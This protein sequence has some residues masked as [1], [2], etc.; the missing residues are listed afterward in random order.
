MIA[1]Y[2]DALRG[3]HRNTRLM[4]T[5]S[6]LLGFT[7]DGGIYSV[8]LNLYILRLNFGPEFVGLVNSVANLVFAFGCLAAGWLGSRWGGRPTMIL[9]LSLTVVGTATLPLANFLPM[10]WRAGWLIVTFLIGYSGLAFY[11]V[12][13]G[14]FLLRVTPQAASGNIFSLQSAIN[15]TASFVGGLTG[16]FLPG[17][18]AI[19]MGVTLTQPAPYSTTL[20]LVSLFIGVALVVLL[21]TSNPE[22]AP[23]LVVPAKDGGAPSRE[24]AYGLILFMGLVRFLQVAGIGAAMVF[25]NVYMDESLGVTTAGI[26]VAAAAARLLA[27][28]MALLAPS[29]GRRFGYG[30]TAVFA[31]LAACVSLL[32]LALVPTPLA[33]S[34]G[35]IG[36]LS[37]TSMRWPAFYVYMME[38]TPERLRAVM[39]GVNEMAAG[40]SFAFIALVGGI[41]IVN[42]GYTATFLFSAFLTLAGALIFAGFVRLRGH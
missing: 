7:I 26:G 20:F 6:A 9:G 21:Q 1:A 35:F 16:G 24:S 4:L 25:F 13:S 23:A 27:V 33:A 37:F 12:N 5:I 18:F 29:L 22:P 3:A 40:L 30:S 2:R 42:Y 34:M 32:P 15:A 41:I 10:D 38:R 17:I 36:L 19:F 39:N 14:P 28:P 8:L 31:S 11:Y